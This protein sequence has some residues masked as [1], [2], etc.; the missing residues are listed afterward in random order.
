MKT[1]K[2]ISPTESYVLDVP[3]DAHEDVDER[4]SSY[5]LD[6]NSLLQISS[7]VRV[8]G[9]Q[10]SAVQRLKD[11]LADER[12]PTV[13]YETIS[14]ISCPETAAASG[15]DEAGCR[16]VFV[17]GVWPDLAILATISGPP[18]EMEKRAAWAF[19]AIRTLRRSL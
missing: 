14:F 9:P 8:A 4:V 16:W 19:D 1:L 10:V 11:R 5:W 6:G 3:S 2:T 17:Y 13:N 12:F 15:V 7:Y 18:D